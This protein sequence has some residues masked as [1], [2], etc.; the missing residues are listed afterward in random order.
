MPFSCREMFSLQNTMPPSCGKSTSWAPFA[1]NRRSR[2]STSLIS[3]NIHGGQRR[4]RQT[5][6]NGDVGMVAFTGQRKRAIDI[7]G[8]ACHLLKFSL[9]SQQIDKLFARFH[10]SN[11]WELDGPMPT[12]SDSRIK[13]NACQNAICSLRERIMP[14]VIYAPN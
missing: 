6:S 1:S 3:V 9:F 7:Y 13:K 2:C 4:A 11:A 10:R 14:A 8:D 12:F 5:H